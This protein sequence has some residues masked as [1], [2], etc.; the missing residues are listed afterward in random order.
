MKRKRVL[1]I[2][3]LI[4][5]VAM[6]ATSGVMVGGKGAK[7]I[8]PTVAASQ[9]QEEAR[10]RQLVRVWVHGDGIQPSVLFARP[11]KIFFNVENET[12][13]DI[14]LAIERV[15][16]GQA[17]ARVKALGTQRKARRVGEEMTLGPGEY[18]VYEETQP[19]YRAR[20]IVEPRK[21]DD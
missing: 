14:S 6:L 19:Q 1:L 17:N 9:A 10:H 7:E 15:T 21:A 4:G 5:L 13:S 20:L 18:V 11:G 3:L 2:V 16:Q 12:Q 8:V